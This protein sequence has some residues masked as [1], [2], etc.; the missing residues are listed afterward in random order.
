MQSCHHLMVWKGNFRTISR[1][2]VHGWRKIKNR[3]EK[4]LAWR[5]TVVPFL[6]Q[7]T[8]TGHQAY[9]LY[10]FLINFTWCLFSQINKQAISFP[11][12]MQFLLYLNTF[13]VVIIN[14]SVTY[15][16]CVIMTTPAFAVGSDSFPSHFTFAFLSIEYDIS[17]KLTKMDINNG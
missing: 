1:R 6:Y 9:L 17:E 13:C 14:Q 10:C 16:I 2:S 4:V 11:Q 5:Y 12:L 15:S 8:N 7:I 3:S